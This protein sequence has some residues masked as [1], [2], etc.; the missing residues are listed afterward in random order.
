MNLFQGDKDIR[1]YNCTPRIGVE[2]RIAR[3]IV[4]ATPGHRKRMR[5]AVVNRNFAEKGLKKLFGGGA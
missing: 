4:N 5:Q 3:S 1:P 2:P